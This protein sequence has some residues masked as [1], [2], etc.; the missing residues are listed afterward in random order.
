MG[1]SQEALRRRPGRNDSLSVSGTGRH[2]RILT[3]PTKAGTATEGETIT[4]TNGTFKGASTV[5]ITRQWI[6]VAVPSGAQTVI[7]GQTG[8][9]YVLAEA[10]VGNKIIFQNTG[11]D[12]ELRATKSQSTPTATVAEGA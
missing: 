7:A 9:T 2:P 3:K 10:D 6:R 11:T 1:R 4:G 5:T 12:E 8:A